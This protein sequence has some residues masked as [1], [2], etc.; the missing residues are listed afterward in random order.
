[1][2]TKL[3]NNN[4]LTSIMDKYDEELRYL[5]DEDL[6]SNLKEMCGDDYDTLKYA[7]DEIS[8]TSVVKYEIYGD[9]EIYDVEE[10]LSDNAYYVDSDEFCKDEDGNWQWYESGGSVDACRMVINLKEK[11]WYWDWVCK[12]TTEKINDVWL[13]TNNDGNDIHLTDNEP[14]D[15]MYDKCN[16]ISI[17][18][19]N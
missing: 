2:A 9:W 6:L 1:M 12:H 13:F 11:K 16:L 7:F 3:Y 15:F 19:M 18:H 17:A 8:D 4:L 14:P 10:W 5:T